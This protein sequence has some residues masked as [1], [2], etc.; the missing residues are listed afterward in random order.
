MLNFSLAQGKLI[1][2]PKQRIVASVVS[3]LDNAMHT[4]SW[5]NTELT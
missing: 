1:A 2:H 3:Q 5:C 4:N